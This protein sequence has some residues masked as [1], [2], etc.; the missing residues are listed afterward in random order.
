V[1]AAP[2]RRNGEGVAGSGMGIGS[3]IRGSV[4]ESRHPLAGVTALLFVKA[5]FSEELSPA[6]E[7][8]GSHG[9]QRLGG[10]VALLRHLAAIEDTVVLTTDEGLHCSVG[11]VIAQLHWWALHE[12]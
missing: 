3:L 4:R 5:G 8:L 9:V 1:R 2:L 12:V 7:R 11:D 10:G 6:A